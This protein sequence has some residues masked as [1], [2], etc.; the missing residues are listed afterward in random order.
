MKSIQ[1]YA[2]A[3]ILILLAACAHSSEAP[4][5]VF[6]AKAKSQLE[7]TSMPVYLPA[8]IPPLS[9][10]QRP[11]Y[12][13]VTL[14]PQGYFVSVDP[15]KNCYGSKS[16]SF[17]ALTGRSGGEPVSGGVV[18]L[19]DGTNARFVAV[20]CGVS[21]TVDSLAWTRNQYTYGV[22][23]KNGDQATLLRIADSFV[24]LN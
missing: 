16:C 7:L 8:W 10:P 21:C 15:V 3:A 19:H 22:Q 20:P 12:A 23:M 1:R 4:S 9:G 11:L 17:V 14:Y 2:C 6:D 13:S 24:P 5:A 18:Q